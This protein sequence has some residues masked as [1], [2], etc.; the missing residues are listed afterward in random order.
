MKK[1]SFQF[2]SND[3]SVASDD[4]T[5]PPLFTESETLPNVPRREQTEAVVVRAFG[6]RRTALPSSP[7]R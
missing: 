7:V 6:R 1:L 2:R 5:Q 3:V 4:L